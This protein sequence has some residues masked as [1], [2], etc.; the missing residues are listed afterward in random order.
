METSTCQKREQCRMPYEKPTVTELTS[1]EAKLKLV[2]H[3]SLGNQG[4]KDMMVMLF[5]EEAKKLST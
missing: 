1:E 2:H 3:A 4:A 5:P